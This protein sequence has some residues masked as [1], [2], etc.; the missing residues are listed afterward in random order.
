MAE[1]S[2]LYRV[3]LELSNLDEHHY[4]S[5][6]LRVAAHPSEN[7]ERLVTR[8]LAM[9]LLREEGLQ[10]SRGL[11][12]GE[13]AS[14]W[15]HDLTGR[16]THWVDVGTPSADRMHQAR[17]A[18]E[19]VTVVC[20]QGAEGL[21]RELRGK[22]VHKADSIEVILLEPS[23]ISAAVR[24]LDRSV[25]WTLVISDG[26][27]SLSMGEETLNCPILRHSLASLRNS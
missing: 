10:F 4:E 12:N 1:P 16:L 14:L 19:R 5:L 15:T 11:S 26:E 21:Q 6:N 2:T 13:E 27:L 17:K 24:G 7:A 9:A 20:H 18:C 3:R 8:V 23:L 25:D 22:N